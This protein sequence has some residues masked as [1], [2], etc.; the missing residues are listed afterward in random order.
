MSQ[1]PSRSQPDPE[2]RFKPFL[3][4]GGLALALVA[5]PVTVAPDL[6]SI[7]WQTAHGK[8]N[9]GGPGNG[10]GPG[11]GHAHGPGDRGPGKSDHGPKGHGYAYGKGGGQGHGRPS[12]YGS[13]GEFKE[14][15]QSGKAFGLERRDE[16][17]EAAKARYDTAVSNGRRKGQQDPADFGVGKVAHRFTPEEAKALME[18]GW[19]GP[20]ARAADGFKNHGERVRTMVEL[21]KRLGYGAHVGALQANFGTP[22]ENGIRELETELAEARTALDA[23]PDEAELQ[24][25]VAELEAELDAAITAAKPGKGPDDSWATADLDVNQDGVIDQRDLEALDDQAADG[26]ASSTQPAA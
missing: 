19:K 22:Q 15:M 23:S 17:V 6:A 18:R 8:G 24:A 25:R 9:G 16:R 26:T 21:A 2:F 5:A 7:E 11:N 20:K 3:V 4:V 14:A 13:F 10:N 12:E 1:A